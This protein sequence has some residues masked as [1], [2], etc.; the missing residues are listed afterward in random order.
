MFQ[1]IPGGTVIIGA[2]ANNLRLEKCQRVAVP[3]S[4]NDV[5][6]R[7]LTGC[8]APGCMTCIR[9]KCTIYNAG[10]RLHENAERHLKPPD[11]MAR[12][13]RHY[14]DAINRTKEISAACQ[15]SLDSLKYEYPEEI[16]TDGRTPQE[17]LILLAWEGAKE[18]S[19]EISLKK[20]LR[21]INHELVYEQMNSAVV[22]TFMNRKVAD[23]G[24]PLPGRGS[25]QTQK[26]V[27]PGITSGI[28]EIDLWFERFISCAQ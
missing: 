20:K 25:G 21:S 11:E 24:N 2:D 15:F 14:P 7:T 19:G 26:F 28:N 13:F 9:E 22:R 4:N 5:I 23:P 17:E 8:A 16:T 12:L 27:W 3:W 6:M 1:L 18:K 10:F